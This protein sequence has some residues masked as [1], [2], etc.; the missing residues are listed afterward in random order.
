[1]LHGVCRCTRTQER[2]IAGTRAKRLNGFCPQSTR[3]N[4]RA[5]V[6]T[7]IT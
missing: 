5:L 6:V 7:D 2:E 4:V 3:R 1:V